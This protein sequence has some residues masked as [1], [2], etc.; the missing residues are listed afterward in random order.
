MNPSE[1][2]SSDADAPLLTPAHLGAAA[3]RSHAS[4]SHEPATRVLTEEGFYVSDRVLS[5]IYLLWHIA[6]FYLVGG[7]GSG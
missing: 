6:S 4:T 2:L 7:T 3:Y 5:Y 1:T